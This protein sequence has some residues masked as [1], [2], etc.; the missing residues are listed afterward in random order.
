MAENKKVNVVLKSGRSYTIGKTR[1]EKNVIYQVDEERAKYLIRMG[2]FI[3]VSDLELEMKK[4]ELANKQKVKDGVI[5]MEDSETQKIGAKKKET[6][7]VDK[8]EDNIEEKE[9][10]K[11]EKDKKP[12]EWVCACCLKTYKSEASLKGHI[13]A[14][15][16]CRL[17][18]KK[19]QGK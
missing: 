5:I 12:K 16:K 15:K 3:T 10:V 2:K 7:V 19:A 17:F 18:Y 14:V 4:E 13:N 8:T 9:E 6:P 1:Y 11:K